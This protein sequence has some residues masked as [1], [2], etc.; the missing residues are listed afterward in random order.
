MK[1]NTTTR[2][3][4]DLNSFI[5]NEANYCLDHQGTIETLE[6]SLRKLNS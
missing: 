2:K 3:F 5:T 6:K 4:N 1:I